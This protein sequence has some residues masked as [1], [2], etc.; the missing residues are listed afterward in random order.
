M[1][2]I[3]DL[4][5]MYLIRFNIDRMVIIKSYRVIHIDFYFFTCV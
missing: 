2:Y 3:D 5:D 1:S 4:N